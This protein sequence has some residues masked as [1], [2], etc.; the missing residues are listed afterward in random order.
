MAN[1]KTTPALTHAELEKVAKQFHMLSDP[2]RLKILQ[3]LHAG[4]RSVGEIVYATGAM[5][6]NISKHLSLLSSAGIVTRH[7]DGQFVYYGVS[8]P[9]MLKLCELV[10]KELLTRS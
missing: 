5:Q 2:M 1:A 4:S 8:R 10:H 9:L 6:S 7:K 3:T